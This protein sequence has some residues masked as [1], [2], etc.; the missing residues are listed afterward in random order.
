MLNMNIATLFT[1]ISLVLLFSTLTPT[2]AKN[3]TTK[4]KLQHSINYHKVTDIS[5]YLVSEKLDGIRGHWNG[6][7]LITRSGNLINSPSWFTEH[8]PEFPI[9]GE[10]WL[11]RDTFQPLMSCVSRHL[12][13]INKQTSCWKNIRFMMFDLP[14]HQG[15]FRKRVDKMKSIVEQVPSPYLAMINQVKLNNINELETKL[16]TIISAKGEGLMLHLASAFYQAGRN[17]ALLKL[18]RHQ[19]AEATI[20]GH[21]AGKG[22]YLGKLGAIKVK[23]SNGVIFKIGSGFSDYQR[24]NPPE[25]GTIITFKY[26]GL[27]Q[28]GKPR[29]AR[30][31]RVRSKK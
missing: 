9:D 1:C 8:W 17:P 3:Q 31:W 23:T 7:Q 26:N 28:A 19:D 27:T 12:P 6:K 18:K 21:S 13:S 30:F 29:F 20:I 15:T 16:D 2:Q 11:D 10:L 24:A 5:K 14:E 22:K 25:I 4:P